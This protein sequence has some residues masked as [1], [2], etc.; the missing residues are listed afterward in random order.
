MSGDS[1]TSLRETLRARD[2]F[3]GLDLARLQA[4]Y[5]LLRWGRNA[6]ARPLAE[7]MPA[8]LGFRGQAI[9]VLGKSGD[10]IR[11]MEMIRNLRALPDTT[12][13][14][15]TALFYGYLGVGDNASALSEFEK[16][17]RVREI[18][19]KWIPLGN[20]M[21]DSVRGNPRFAAVVHGFGLDEK[22]FIPPN[23][24]RPGK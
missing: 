18:T 24:G 15:H 14:V 7:T 17:L 12:W 4:A 11:A 16:A 19:P 3:P 2:Q 21:F 5:E 10:R 8:S 9:Y 1:V 22:L 6:E 23:R 13:L 20:P